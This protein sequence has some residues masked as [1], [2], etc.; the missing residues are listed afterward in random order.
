MKHVIKD[1]DK[2]LDEEIHTARSGN[3]LSAGTSV[4]VDL[5]CITLLLGEQFTNLE[6]LLNLCYWDFMEASSLRHDQL[7]SQLLSPLEG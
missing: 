6:V 5:G 4:P 2:Q 7:Y 3:V 1:T